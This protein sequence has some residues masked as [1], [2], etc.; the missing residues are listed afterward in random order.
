MK[1]KAGAS[2]CPPARGGVALRSAH[3]AARGPAS[4]ADRLVSFITQL[5]FLALWKS[6]TTLSAPIA[7]LLGLYLWAGRSA[8]KLASW[9]QRLLLHLVGW[10][11]GPAF[12]KSAWLRAWGRN[13]VPLDL[14]KWHVAV[15]EPLGRAQQP[16]ARQQQPPAHARATQPCCCA[17]RQPPPP[18]R[19]PC[20]SRHGHG[21]PGGQ[22]GAA[23]AREL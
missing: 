20:R 9:L 5:T 18:A 19:R 15:G 16:I 22:P 8:L 17:P 7:R 10:L 13:Y 3:K 11:A 21:Q 14:R 1:A 12:P 4:N 2:L 6:L 23:L